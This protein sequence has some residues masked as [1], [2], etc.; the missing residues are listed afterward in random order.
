MTRRR[1]E[2]LGTTMKLVK[3]GLFALLLMVIASGPSSSFANE[4]TIRFAVEPIPP[5]VVGEDGKPAEGAL[6]EVMQRVCASAKRTCT[7]EIMP[8]RRSL[9][10][11]I[12]GAEVD[13]ILPS[14]RIPEREQSFLISDPVV[15]TAYSFFASAQSSWQF[16]SPADLNGMLIVAYGP[17][18][19]SIAVEN[20][21]LHTSATLQ[22]E[23][24]MPRALEK[25]AGGRYG[26]DAAVVMN[27]DT[28]L[29]LLQDQKIPGLKLAGDLKSVEYCFGLS[30]KSSRAGQMTVLNNAL[31][32]LQKSGEIQA[33]LAKYGLQDASK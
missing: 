28:G 14:I 2:K 8:F 33:I 18:A 12:E 16:Q 17:S 30:R 31:H 15:K 19:T 7:F 26:A 10:I 23:L 24:N 5:F 21:I 4:E 6:V 32:Q 20:A 3:L 9:A 22:I 1:C 27:R 25:L 13:G 11:A 29:L